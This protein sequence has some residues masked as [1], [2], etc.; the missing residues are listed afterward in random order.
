MLEDQGLWRPQGQSGER[1]CV[2]FGPFRLFPTAR[3]LQRSGISA[4][5]GARALDILIALVDRAGEVVTSDELTRVVW[6][7][8]TVVDANLRMQ[9]SA[10]RRALGS[11]SANYISN[12]SGRGY[13]FTAPVS[14]SSRGQHAGSEPH[15]VSRRSSL[16]LRPRRTVGRQEMVKEVV[17]TLT[18][19]RF[20][21]IA[22]SA[23]IGKTTIAI[24]VS[25][26]LL[27]DFDD[28]I[29]FI[30]LGSL[31]D[32]E[33]IDTALLNALGLSGSKKDLLP[34]L[35]SFTQGRPLLLVFD[36]CEHLI[37]EVAA[38]VERLHKTIQN[39]SILA[40]SR[41]AMRAEGEHVVRLEPLRYPPLSE[42]LP[43]DEAMFLL[44]QRCIVVGM[45][46]GAVKGNAEVCLAG[47][48]IDRVS[49]RFGDLEV[50]TRLNTHRR[51][52]KSWLVG[53]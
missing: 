19:S 48:E 18:A 33:L 38:L 42:R 50:S 31:D 16:P 14:W 7:K 43:A 21:T 3:L 2:S 34:R 41:E 46:A 10:L 15:N 8:T 4:K 23:G 49:K 28:E 6:P 25:Y 35:A 1:N 13:C 11:E 40:T 51:W 52:R 5:I 27:D 47:V 36:N 29:Y 24:L 22:G 44:A 17:R 12:V 20:V 45:I 37:A 32:A 30:D 53:L 26:D 39:V 9:M